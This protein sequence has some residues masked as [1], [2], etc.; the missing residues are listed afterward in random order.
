MAAR[1]RALRALLAVDPKAPGAANQLVDTLLALGRPYDAFRVARKQAPERLAS[2]LALQAIEREYVP[3][4]EA[5]LDGRLRE[6]QV[7]HDRFALPRFQLAWSGSVRGWGRLRVLASGQWPESDDVPAGEPYGSFEALPATFASPSDEGIGGLVQWA[8]WDGFA[9]ELGTTPTSFEVSNLIGALRYRSE[10][11]AGEFVAGVD[12]S[13]VED[14]LL[15]YAGSVDPLDGRAWGG[16]VRERGY[17]GGRLRSGE[18]GI[19]GFIAGAALDGERV[20][21]NT[22]WRADAGFT[23]LAASGGN[24]VA[25]VGGAFELLGMDDNRS[26]FTLGHGGYFSPEHFLSVGP[27]FDI[28]GHGDNRSF[29]IEGGVLWQEVREDSSPYFPT[30][31]ALQA[32]S[33][34]PRYAGNA[35]DGIGVRISASLEWRM[36]DRTVAGLRLEGVRG[37]DADEVRLQIYTRRWDHRV[38]DPVERPPVPFRSTGHYALN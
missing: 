25:H 9:L 30:D 20:D 11:E 28:Q 35:R 21:S 7:E 27:V 31:D 12:R 33:G 15:S 4:F 14:S 26:H 8:P 3:H 19:Y 1:E 17:L 23:K 18:F 10:S 38:S 24:W 2:D 29:R 22:E 32:A 6:G 34:N 36:T 5:A 16:V 37:E 13:A